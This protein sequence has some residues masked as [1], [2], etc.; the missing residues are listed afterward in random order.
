MH[1]ISFILIWP[2]M[3]L[4]QSP[5]I[6]SNFLVRTSYKGKTQE[7]LWRLG[8]P[9]TWC[10]FSHCQCRRQAGHTPWY[11]FFFITASPYF[12]YKNEEKIALPMYEEL[13]LHWEFLEKVSLTGCNCLFMLVLEIGRDSWKRH[14]WPHNKLRLTTASAIFKMLNS[15]VGS[16][17]VKMKV[18]LCPLQSSLV[19]KWQRQLPATPSILCSKR[20]SSWAWTKLLFCG[21]MTSWVV[22]CWQ[23]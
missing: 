12:Q 11:R 2:I 5:N 23:I 6:I 3:H 18:P 20:H 8:G 1:P 13:L 17:Y 16:N 9:P 15:Y 7:S 21:R 4:K 10:S 22:R 19:S 14:F